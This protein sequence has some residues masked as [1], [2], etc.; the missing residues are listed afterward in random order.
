MI[1]LYIYTETRIQNRKEYPR[2]KALNFLVAY[3]TVL[4][5]TIKRESGAQ[6]ETPQP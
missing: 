6:M 3:T 5:T 2:K 4:I 1:E